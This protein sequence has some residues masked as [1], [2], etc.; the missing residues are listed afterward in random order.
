MRSVVKWIVTNVLPGLFVTAVLLLLL[1]VGAEIYFRIEWPFAETTWTSRF[2]PQLGFTFVPGAVIRH[3]NYLDFW[4]EQ[5]ANSLGFLDR[6]PP[7]E[8]TAG[9]HDRIL[10]VGDSFVE[11]A[12]VPIE[13]KVQVRLERL[14]N[15]R[16]PSNPVETMAFGY[17]GTG[18]ANQLP[19]LEL[20]KPYSPCLV[21]L[22]F[23]NNDFANNS[24][25]LEAVR[26]GWHPD[27]AP[28]P[29]FRDRE[30]KYV[31]Q[32]PDP[33][34]QKYILPGQTGSA[35]ATWTMRPNIIFD[36]LGPALNGRSYLYTAIKHAWISSANSAPDYYGNAPSALRSLRSLPETG[37]RFG[38]WTP[39]DDLTLD[40]MFY[41]LNPP[42]VF[43]EAIRDTAQAVRAW[44]ERAISMG[45]SVVILATHSLRR[46]LIGREGDKARLARRLTNADAQFQRLVQIGQN[47]GIPVIDQTAFLKEKGLD[48]KDASFAHD[49]HWNE[50]GHESAAGALLE[51]LQ[52]APSVCPRR[53]E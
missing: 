2:D 16:H 25:W 1:A 47:L 46:P 52:Q 50:T 29:F 31:L 42:P 10:I 7:R 17:S 5:R 32:L 48:P 44:K 3:T 6:E 22:V 28:R 19:W 34:W 43:D 23:V 45:A 24:A 14:W 15:E 38:D 27:H 40:E 39:P 36:M 51:W 12:Q 18:Q 4:S 41:A 37:D 35:Q 30:G 33:N 49:G 11:A 53:K 13:K 9:G 8:P 20:A 26:N 21:V